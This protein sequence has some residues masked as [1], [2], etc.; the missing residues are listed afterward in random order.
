MSLGTQRDLLVDYLTATGP[1]LR[2]A[3]DLL[4]VGNFLQCL[5]EIEVTVS[6]SHFLANVSS[7]ENN[8]T[9]LYSAV[10][11]MQSL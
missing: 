1:C 7:G 5:Y 3:R 11:F 2:P 9:N 10:Q 6:C 8:D 4:L